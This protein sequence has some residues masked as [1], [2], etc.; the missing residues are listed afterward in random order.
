MYFAFDVHSNLLN[1]GDGGIF[2]F[3][4][5]TDVQRSCVNTGITFFLIFIITV[6]C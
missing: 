4:E 5:E 1:M 6:V 2:I 3:R